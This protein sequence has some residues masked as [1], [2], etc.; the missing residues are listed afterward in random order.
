MTKALRLITARLLTSLV[1]LLIVATAI[2]WSTSLGAGDT[3]TQILGREAPPQA[4]A[5][6]R[7]RLHLNEPFT[8]R[9][10]HWLSGV[11]RFDFGE[12]VAAQRPVTSI[13]VP[14]LRNSLILAMAGF[15]LYIP[16]TLC[17]AVV[18][19][20]Y[21]G[22]APDHL[23]S[24]FTLTV[25][26]SLAD[27]VLGTFLLAF[28]VLVIP[29]VP[30][31][32]DIELARTFGDYVRM[33]ALPAVTVS[34]SMSAYGIRMLRGNLI[35]VL[36]SDYVQWATLKGMPRWR[37][38]FR[39]ALPSALTPFLNVTALNLTYLFGG[40]IPVEIVFGY[41][42]I[43]SLLVESIQLRDAPLIAAVTL[44][45]SAVYIGANLVADVAAILL[46]PRLRT[47]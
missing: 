33:L 16:L 20:V 4:V 40:L 2:F 43:G 17:G 13:I 27:F 30:A 10:V 38:V 34:A 45:P 6:L 46:T 22:R 12:S 29:V 1:V 14:R 21:R 31:V 18:S 44:I 7:A 28:F 37:V 39:H 41:P 9:Y 47:A 36:E 3:A 25:G 19:A 11:A 24:L 26:L 23:I 8:Q 5:A 42:G 32:S 35:E 15:L